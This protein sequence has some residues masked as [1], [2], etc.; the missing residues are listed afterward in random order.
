MFLQKLTAFFMALLTM[1][2]GNAVS[3]LDSTEAEPITATEREYRFDQDKLLLGVYC[4]RKDEHY[5]NLRQWFKEAGLQFAVCISGK[6]YTD[7]DFAWF[8][9]NGLGILAPRTE[10]YLNMKQDAIWGIDLRDE[11]GAADFPALADRVREMYAEDANRFPLINLFPMYASS[12]QLGETP[13]FEGNDSRLD[14]LNADSDKYRQHVSDYLG[15]ID[16]D[17]VSVDIYPLNVS[18]ETG[19]RSTYEY[20]LRNLDILAEGCRLTN[21]DLW[22]I[23]Q[24]A[25]DTDGGGAKRHCDTVEDQRWQNYVS[26][27][28]GAKA[29]IYGCYYTGW[30][31]ASS[32]MIDADG[33]RTA[34]YY[35]VQQANRELAAFADVYGRYQNHGAVLYNRLNPNAAGA[36]LPLTK[37]DRQY[38]PNVLTAAPV[39][40]GCFT[41]KEGDGSA[42][43][44]TNM[45]EPEPGKAATFTASF[46]GAKSL[47]V[48]R[49]GGATVIPGSRLTLTLGSEEGVFVTVQNGAG[50][51]PVC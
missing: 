28:F 5:E 19:E 13:L 46:P 48:Y 42:F 10:Y 44:F 6:E 51:G 37:I 34:T 50:K 11:P 43:V 1:F 2:S 25:G 21:R 17:I 36:K 40:C 49:K 35:A 12:E 3:V 9:Q 16:S 30:W 41:E 24:A 32:H 22:V 27:A 39:L 14:G 47:T 20:W 4:F 45:Y 29:I 18:P 33:N 38:Q 7:E 23:T 26:L 8:E 15:Q 31:D